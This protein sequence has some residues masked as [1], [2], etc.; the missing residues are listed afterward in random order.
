MSPRRIKDVAHRLS[1]LGTGI[2]RR[3]PDFDMRE[4]LKAGVTAVGGAPGTGE[5]AIAGRDYGLRMLLGM[6]RR[7]FG[8]GGPGSGPA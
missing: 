2:A 7:L 4:I 8:S 6:G 3:V 5:V 1:R